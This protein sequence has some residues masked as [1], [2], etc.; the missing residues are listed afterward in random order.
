[1]DFHRF[2]AAVVDQMEQ[3]CRNL[4]GDR[5]VRRPDTGERRIKKIRVFVIPHPNDRDVARDLAVAVL[6]RLIGA[7]HEAVGHS[8]KSGCRE[9]CRRAFRV[10][11]AR[12][13]RPA[14]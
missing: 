2:Y 6:D 10:S 5:V 1:M 14:G 11:L 13:G 12:T 3:A 9:I 7:E 4:L 8:V